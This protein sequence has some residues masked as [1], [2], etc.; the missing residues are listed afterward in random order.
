MI[1]GLSV[2]FGLIGVCYSIAWLVSFADR[3]NDITDERAY[4]DVAHLPP[5]LV[6][7]NHGEEA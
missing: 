1:I 6:H 4:G 2:A 5:V 7:R 3:Q